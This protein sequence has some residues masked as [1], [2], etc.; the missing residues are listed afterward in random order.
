MTFQSLMIE[1][2]PDSASAKA[3]YQPGVHG[4][5]FASLNAYSFP[6]SA[7]VFAKANNLDVIEVDNCWIRV[8][9]PGSKLREFLNCESPGDPDLPDI[10]A[11]I[12][13]DA[14]YLLSEEEF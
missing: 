4:E 8:P 2:Y 9:L 13:D 12:E 5:V 1:T 3:P 7:W 6:R 10:A 11:R 14:W